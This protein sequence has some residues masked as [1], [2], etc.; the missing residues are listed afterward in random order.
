MLQTAS[1]TKYL[2]I[3]IYQDAEFIISFIVKLYLGYMAERAATI[4]PG[5]IAINRQ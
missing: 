5:V 3:F 2:S 1:Q 4:T